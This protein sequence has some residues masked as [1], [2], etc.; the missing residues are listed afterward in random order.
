MTTTRDAGVRPR[1]RPRWPRRIRA[2]ASA[3]STSSANASGDPVA[4]VVGLE[5][6]RG[7]VGHDGAVVD[8]HDPLG[9]RVRL[10]EVVGGEHDR[11]AVALA[12]GDDVLL[13]VGAV[14]RVQAGGRLVEEQQVGGVDQPHRDVEAS[15]L[16][17]GERW[18]PCGPRRSSRPSDSTSSSARAAAVR[19]VQTV[20]PALAD[21][22]VARPLV[23]PGTVALA[24]VADPP[25]HQRA[26]GWSRRTRPRV[27]VP[28]VGAISVVSIRSVVDLPAPLG[29]S[30][31]TS[32]PRSTVRSR[33][34]TASTVCLPT[35]KCLGQRVG[36]GSSSSVMGPRRYERFRTV[37]VLKPG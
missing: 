26:A 37:P 13:Q 15:P 23:V 32:S 12:Q 33:P 36:R 8:H 34:R 29:P 18:T 21:Q 9:E 14:L 10:V 25:S 24:D 16:A 28:D 31:A 17:A 27:A 3:A 7:V 11:G 22:L 1:R 35:V 2:A 30:R 4:G 20:G 19:R 6:G 5:P